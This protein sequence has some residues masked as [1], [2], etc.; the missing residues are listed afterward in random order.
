MHFLIRP[1]ISF[2]CSLLKIWNLNNCTGVLGV[3]NCQGAGSWPGME[4][5]DLEDEDILEIS[6]KV[7]LNDIEYLEE[8]TGDAWNGDAAVFSFKSGLSQLLIGNIFNEKIHCLY[9]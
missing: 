5:A 7:S 1:F 9:F 6:C 8:V 4:V 3:F 2:I